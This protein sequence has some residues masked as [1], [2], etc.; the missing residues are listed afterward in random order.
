MHICMPNVNLYAS[1]IYFYI[2]Q[3]IRPSVDKCLFKYL[4]KKTR[5]D[6]NILQGIQLET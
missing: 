5:E 3:V 6:E 4:N 1:I 2:V